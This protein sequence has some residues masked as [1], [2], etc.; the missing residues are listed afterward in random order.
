MIER[1]ITKNEKDHRNDEEK[2]FTRIW[3]RERKQ[4]NNVNRRIV[5]DVVMIYLIIYLNI[6]LYQNQQSSFMRRFI[7]IYK[8]FD[9]LW[10]FQNKRSNKEFIEKEVSR[11]EQKMRIMTFIYISTLKIVSNNFMMQKTKNRFK[12]FRSR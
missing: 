8:N 3:K 11:S 6:V 9:D 5:D 7:E 1:I 2:T 10:W 12:R 4:R